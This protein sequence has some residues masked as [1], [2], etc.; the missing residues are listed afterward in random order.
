MKTFKGTI[1]DFLLILSEDSRGEYSPKI[2]SFYDYLTK[3]MHIN[4]DTYCNYL[5]SMKI[6]DIIKSMNKY[7][8]KSSINKKSV[9]SYYKTVIKKYFKYLNTISISNSK[10]I[11]SFGVERDDANSYDGIINDAINNNPLLIDKDSN[12]PIDKEEAEILIDECNDVIDEILINN[13]NTLKNRNTYQRLVNFL[14]IK[15][16]MFT[17]A[18]PNVIYKLDIGNVN[19]ES[20]KLLINGFNIHLPDKLAKQLKG[21]INLRKCMKPST[22]NL[23]VNYNGESISRQN[24]R[25]PYFLSIICLGVSTTAIT[26]YTVIEMINVGLNPSIIKKLTGVGSDIYD[27]CQDRV[28]NNRLNDVNSYINSRLLKTQHY[29]EL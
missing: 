10:L 22:D 28:N 13:T 19:T 23:F 8:E 4:D 26:K 2:Y 3:E 16:L 24:T 15:V 12:E 27:F 29:N 6:P 18:K 25:V 20:N 11:E 14:F 1:E 9:A 5:Q 7:I 21:Y 17:G